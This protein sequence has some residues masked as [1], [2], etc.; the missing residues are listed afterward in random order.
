MDDILLDLFA[1]A[2]LGAGWSLVALGGY[3]RGELAPFSD[4]DLMLL[5]DGRPKKEVDEAARQVFYPL[6]DSGLEVGNAVR[7]VRQALAVASDSL[8]TQTTLLDARLLVGPSEPLAQLQAQLKARLAKGR[9]KRFFEELR[10]W[11]AERH[12]EFGQSAYL[13]EPHIKEGLGGLRD[14]QA[15]GWVGKGLLAGDGL[16]A[17]AGA[18]HLTVE[19]AR[20]LQ[21]ADAFLWTVRT[22]LHEKAGRQ[23]DRI[24]FG[25]QIELARALGYV[26]D[27]GYRAAE[28]FMSDVFA[29]T[30]QV[31]RVSTLFWQRQAAARRRPSKAWRPLEDD[32]IVRDGQ[33]ELADAKAL[34]GSP[35]LTFRLFAAAAEAGL[36]VSADAI[37]AVQRSLPDGDSA[38]AEW[39]PEVRRA[40]LDLLMQGSHALPHLE[41]LTQMG[42]FNRFIPE[43]DQA[44]SRVQFDAYHIYTVDLHALHT[45]AELRRLAQGRYAEAEPL[46]T[47]LAAREDDWDTL[48]LSGLLHDIGKGEGHGHAERGAEL[49]PGIVGRMGMDTA[50]QEAVT[51]L[52]GRHLL[53]YNTAT[54]RDLNDI[55]VV[56]QTAEAIPDRDRAR[57]LYLLTVADSL[58]TGPRAWTPWKSALVAELTLRVLHL[59]EGKDF[60]PDARRRLV[61]TKREAMRRLSRRYSARAI[62]GFFES[63][64]VGYLTAFDTDDVIRHFELME[65]EHPDPLRTAVRPGK[66]AGLYE[67]TLVTPGQPGL[68]TTVTGALALNGV[69]ILSA[70]VYARHDGRALMVFD[71]S[72][73]FEKSISDAKWERVKADTAKALEGRLALVWRLAERAKRY[74]PSKAPAPGRKPRVVVDNTSSDF[75]TLVEVYTTDRVGLLFKIAQAFDELRLVIHQAHISTAGDEAADVFYVLDRY[76]DKVTDAE[77]VREIHRAIAHSLTP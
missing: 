35:A 66:R 40:F 58:A 25:M 38:P 65:G 10:A 43:W 55:G 68:F 29:R 46:A 70:E 64:P 8:E 23:E 20:A 53:L 9:G 14:I 73:A 34:E 41:L 74:G 45:V 31:E 42:A 22:H 3:G 77:H 67:F 71:V 13:L 57:Q 76:A 33:V 17:L 52:V 27:E 75:F 5:H 60:G 12:E 6:W 37:L 39:T 36:P 28:R 11:L 2:G 21:D 47:E 26:A 49:A 61:D 54:R 1:S 7:T 72:D 56:T 48:L 51:F 44:R 30:G 19:D 15:I 50:T 69:T 32:I 62:D 24:S 63:M 18:G 16:D 4:V 59:M